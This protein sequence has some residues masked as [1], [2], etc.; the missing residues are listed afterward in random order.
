MKYVYVPVYKMAVSYL[1]SF[2][3]RWSILEHMLLTESTS[4]KRTALE[5]A[6]A[7][8]VPHRLV[9]EALINLLRANYV[10]VRSDDSNVYFAATPTGQKRAREKSL[11]EQ[12][13]RDIRWDSMCV[14]RLTG[15]WMR[16]DDLD[17]VHDKD[18][19]PDAVKLRALLHTFE[20]NDA[21][22]RELFRLNLNESLEPAP[23]VFRP[24]SLAFARVGLA[25]NEIQVGLPANPPFALQIALIE[26]SLHVKDD[27]T[28]P[29]HATTIVSDEQAR[30]NLTDDDLIVGGPEHLEVLREALEKAKSAVIIHSCF[31]SA[32]TLRNL[33]PDLERAARRRVKVDLLW[34]LHTD[35]EVKG[36]AKKI[37]DVMAVLAG[38]PPGPRGRIHLSPISSGSHAKVILYDDRDTGK[39]TTIIGSCNFLSS[40]FDWM[41]ISLRTRSP[42]F[43][44][45]VTN[46]LLSSQLPAAGSW[47][48][49]ARR[50][51]AIWSELKGFTRGL[52]ETGTHSIALVTDSDHYA[53]ISLARDQARDDIE[54]VC[55]LYGLSAETSV[56]VPM[57]TAASRGV[58]VRIAYTRESRFLLAEQAMPTPEEVGK[59]GIVLERVADIHAKYMAWDSTNLVITSFN[60]MAT[61]V[62]GKRSRGA[63]MGALI[64]GPDIRTFLSAKLGK[65][66]V[67]NSSYDP[68]S[69]GPIPS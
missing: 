25:F 46:R 59:R 17:L 62:D 21:P 32:D 2:G 66:S 56:L 29:Y 50:L 15:H 63:E 11:P 18:L 53:C 57:E 64:Q 67:Q 42:A 28:T 69:T 39:W 20:P 47:S 10:E 34:G 3:R 43:A 49:T 22:L 5:L 36:P 48:S 40:E 38:L 23:P 44:A 35:P 13:Q 12:L 16:A 41:E 8:N 51:N 26:A 65:S 60:W 55:D 27:G 30:D 31:L 33:A 58:K 45:R 24:P 52:R 54:I 61:S 4:A 14:D 68:A 6:E 37:S 9:V 19:P 7:C 1:F